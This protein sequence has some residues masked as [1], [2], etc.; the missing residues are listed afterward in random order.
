MT[1]SL[2]EK[3]RMELMRYRMERADE[4]IEELNILA[5]SGH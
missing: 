2:D 4:T 1:E 5:G 3:S